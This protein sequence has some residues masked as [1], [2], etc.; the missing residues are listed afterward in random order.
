[1]NDL[2]KLQRKA[3]KSFEPSG[4]GHIL[5]TF[6]RAQMLNESISAES[7]SIT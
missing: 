7:E 3:T 5:E 6:E 2:T 4:D 1:M